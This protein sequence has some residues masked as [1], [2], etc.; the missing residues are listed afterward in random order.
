MKVKDPLTINFFSIF[1]SE[2]DHFY[3]NWAIFE[4]GHFWNGPFLN[5]AIFELDHFWIGPFLQLGHFW[6]D[7]FCNWAISKL[8]HFWIGPFLWN[9]DILELAHFLIWSFR[10]KNC[11][12]EKKPNN[13]KPCRKF[14]SKSSNGSMESKWSKLYPFKLEQN[15]KYL[16]YLP[17]CAIF[18]PNNLHWQITGWF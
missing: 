12:F 15:W 18:E 7:H 13:Q 1:R 6:I 17:F 2:N 10:I 4:L 14:K 5:R 16:S 3:L 9:W 11:L 8:G